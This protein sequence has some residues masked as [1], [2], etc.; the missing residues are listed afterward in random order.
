[1]QCRGSINIKDQSHHFRVHQDRRLNDEGSFLHSHSLS[2]IDVL[3]ICSSVVVE[4]VVNDDF[5]NDD[6]ES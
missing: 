5:V 4:D 6:D 2:F 3:E 1:V